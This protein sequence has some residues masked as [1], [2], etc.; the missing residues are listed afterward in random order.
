MNDNIKNQSPEITDLN[1][2]D[3]DVQ[4]LEQRLEL[5][6]AGSGAETD[7]WICEGVNIEQSV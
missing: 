5:S 6:V 2:T 3:L 1:V 4:E 7:A